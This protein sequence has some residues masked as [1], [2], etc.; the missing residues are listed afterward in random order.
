MVNFVIGALVVHPGGLFAL[1]TLAEGLVARVL[2]D[3]AIVRL[4]MP[5][6][7]A[8]RIPCAKLPCHS[9]TVSMLLQLPRF[10][11]IHEDHR[12]IHLV[13]WRDESEMDL[14]WVESY[15][16]YMLLLVRGGGMLIRNVQRLCE[17]TVF[18]TV[19]RSW[20]TNNVL[21]IRVLPPGREAA[22]NQRT[23]PR[24]QPKSTSDW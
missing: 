11:T 2:K 1:G 13:G 18:N 24:G 22:C 14:S 12:A 4:A 10:I 7:L 16:G 9:V 21:A 17:G 15:V 3:D 23:R 6:E 19:V 5:V 20:F 8:T